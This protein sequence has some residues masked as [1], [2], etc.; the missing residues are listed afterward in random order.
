MAERGFILD[1]ADLIQL[2][3]GVLKRVPEGERPEGLK[4]SRDLL[5]DEGHRTVISHILASELYNPDG[6]WHLLAGKQLGG[7]DYSALIAKLE[8]EGH[9][10]VAE[11]AAPHGVSKA[12]MTQKRLF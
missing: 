7:A 9:G 11:P 4:V 12:K 5:G 3:F 6:P 2:I 1:Q 10:K 8:T